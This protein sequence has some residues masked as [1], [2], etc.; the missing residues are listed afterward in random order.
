LGTGGKRVRASIALAGLFCVALAGCGGAGG[1][2]DPATPAVTAAPLPTP[3]TCEQDLEFVVDS[4]TDVAGT[5]LTAHSGEKGATWTNWSRAGGSGEITDANR[6]R[7]GTVDLH[8]VV[9]ASGTPPGA[10]YEVA[11]EF[12]VASLTEP[13]LI[14]LLGR[15]DDASDS[16]Y[17]GW[18]NTAT[19]QWG[20]SRRLG[21]TG[22]DLGAT[23]ARPL[24]VGRTYQAVLRLR[25]SV[26]VLAVDGTELVTARDDAI[27]AAGAAG[28]RIAQRTRAGNSAG[29][30]LD[31]LRAV[32]LR[33]R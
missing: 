14:G 25:G 29:I 17:L 32:S 21:G 5:Q 22:T 19:G 18:H 16:E 31:G 9:T 3:A 8:A 26:I 24:A 7:A 15:R 30:H 2:R 12:Y 1:D 13:T 6:V 11:G 27:T 23:A 20:I 10:D 4:F 28:V 33:C